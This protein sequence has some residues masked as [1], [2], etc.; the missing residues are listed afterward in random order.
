M[1]EL[2]SPDPSRR[3]PNV[4][5]SPDQT[6]AKV[7][8]RTIPM[9]DTMRRSRAPRSR[10]FGAVT[11]V[12]IDRMLMRHALEQA[13]GDASRL[14]PRSDGSVIIANNQAQARRILGNIAFGALSL[15]ET[16]ARVE[17]LP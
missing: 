1:P 3:L 10:K 14:V 12:A 11:T 7:G 8:S 6:V 15:S 9:Q 16:A 17:G 4:Y 5:T 2:P 13:D